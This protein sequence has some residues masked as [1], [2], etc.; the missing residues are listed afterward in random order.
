MMEGWFV[1]VGL[2]RASRSSESAKNLRRVQGFHSSR[3]SGK[4]L[5]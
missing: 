3:N 1:P 2:M 5:A 4:L